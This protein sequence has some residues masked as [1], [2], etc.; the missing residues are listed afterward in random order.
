MEIQQKQ[1]NSDSLMHLH[2]WF[3]GLCRYSDDQAPFDRFYAEGQIYACREMLGDFETRY[4]DISRGFRFL[5][6]NKYFMNG[7]NA[8][9]KDYKK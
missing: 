2:G 3:K 6:D 9:K 7:Y 8:F 4:H 5:P 1:I